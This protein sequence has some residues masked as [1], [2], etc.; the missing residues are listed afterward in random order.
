MDDDTDDDND[1]NKKN[2]KSIEKIII[3]DEDHINDLRIL[4]RKG[5]E[6]KDRELTIRTI[7]LFTN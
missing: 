6:G 3:D 5:M 7:N 1:D 2:I 4:L